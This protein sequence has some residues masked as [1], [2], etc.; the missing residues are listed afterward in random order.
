MWLKIQ[1]KDELLI[2]RAVKCW[3]ADRNSY[4]WDLRNIRFRLIY[5]SF[6]ES[7]AKDTIYIATPANL[8]T[9]GF[10]DS[11]LHFPTD[12]ICVHFGAQHYFSSINKPL[13]NTIKTVITSSFFTSSWY[14][15]PAMAFLGNR[16]I[17]KAS[18]Y[19]WKLWRFSFP[20]S[21]SF[22]FCVDY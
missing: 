12:W 1:W 22:I 20:Q 10:F 6:F 21:K 5:H 7:S 17:I 16:F 11:F 2:G 8:S 19:H 14:F 15:L 9:I 4:I 13:F 18:L 3:I